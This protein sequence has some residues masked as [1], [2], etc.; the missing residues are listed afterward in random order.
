MV[1]KSAKTLSP[2]RI[3]VKH[4]FAVRSRFIVAVDSVI[5]EDWILLNILLRTIYCCSLGYHATLERQGEDK[6]R[7]EICFV[8]ISELDIIVNLL[9]L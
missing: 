5:C 8:C 3:L 9:I 1:L 7:T 6:M 4:F 2:Y